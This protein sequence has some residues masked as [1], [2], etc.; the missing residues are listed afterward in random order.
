MLVTPYGQNPADR[1]DD[2]GSTL[3]SVLVVMLVLS[4]GGLALA[5]IVTN[6]TS[7]L[8]DSRTTVQSRAAADAGLA[9][10]VNAVR[11]GGVACGTVQR[12]VRVDTTD[13]SSPTYSY[14]VTCGG[15][16]ATIIATGEAGSGR[17]T[18]EAVYRFTETPASAG[19]MVFFGTSN[20]TFTS[21]VKTAAT[22]RLLDI[23]VPRATFV[24]QSLIPGNITVGGDIDANGGCTIKGSVRATG[25]VDMCCGSDVI[26]GD[27]STSGTGSGVV[28]GTVLGNIHANGALVFGYEGKRVGE[29]VTTTGDAT[30][31]NVRIDGSLTL[32][33]SRTL[34]VREGSVAGG[35]SRPTTV[36]PPAAPA[37]PTWFEY[38]F[39]TSDWPGFHLVTLAGSGTGAGTCASF[40]SSPGTGWTTL[41]GYTAPT[42]VDAR[43]CTIL[44]SNNGSNPV[45]SLRTDLVILAKEFD[46]TALTMK[47]NAGV[48][49][50]P[51]VWFVTEDVVP[52]DA[53]PTCGRGYGPL[54]V[55]GTVMAT[56][57][58]A[59]A[60][61]PCVIRVA[62][63]A[64]G[65]DDAWSGAF[66][67]GGW[68]HGDGLTFTAD[69]IALPGMTS[70]SG[71]GGGRGVLGALVSQRDTAPQ[72]IP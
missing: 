72:E 44:S 37:L 50:K 10:A 21:E 6:T 33:A 48:S 26:E 68:S 67:G 61:T 41:A 32:P 4:I 3:V 55:N 17:S 65:I 35:I 29:S 25:E 43:A 71:A 70:G 11:R 58:T 36:A 46:L 54:K 59:M 40:N 64:A 39:Q 24:C 62:G 16:L 27:L 63:E 47:A 14:R 38:R 19:D 49:A 28:R 12:D 45:L 51:K 7:T 5:A 22:G 18:T 8:A 31:G 57:I 52:T 13:A 42:I 23:V 15:G 66:Y 1:A 60:Y 56:S 30:L 34:D 53:N 2:R 9:D 69:P 20:V